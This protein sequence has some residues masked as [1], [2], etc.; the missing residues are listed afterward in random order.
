MAYKQHTVL[1]KLVQGQI[2]EKKITHILIINQL[3]TDAH[4]RPRAVLEG[5]SLQWEKVHFM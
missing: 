5:L 4:Y 3:Y 2:E 1:T